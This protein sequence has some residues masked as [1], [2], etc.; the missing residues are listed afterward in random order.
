[1]ATSDKVNQLSQQ[2]EK[3]Q[4]QKLEFD[5]VIKKAISEEMKELTQKH[6][7]QM[8]VDEIIGKIKSVDDQ[9]KDNVLPR[10][11]GKIED[12]IVKILEGRGHEQKKE[13][14]QLNPQTINAI[15]KRE[16]KSVM[17]E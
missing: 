1:M 16:F 9:L 13:G 11:E 10:L 5:S 6:L 2:V 3:M 7:K 4:Q 12:I 8:L 14:D 17:K 15:I